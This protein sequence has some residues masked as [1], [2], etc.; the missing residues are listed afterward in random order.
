MYQSELDVNQTGSILRYKSSSICKKCGH[1]KVTFFH[2]VTR[3]NKDFFD[4]Y[5][6]FI[7]RSNLKIME[8]NFATV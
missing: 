7:N 3:I 6:Y 8:R 1:H 2:L 5:R 4:F